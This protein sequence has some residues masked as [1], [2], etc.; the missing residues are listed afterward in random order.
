[1]YNL[2]KGV[3]REDLWERCYDAI[4]NTHAVEVAGGGAGG[5]NKTVYAA[6]VIKGAGGC[7]A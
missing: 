4:R 1:M 7:G 2:V 5:S 6:C 3:M